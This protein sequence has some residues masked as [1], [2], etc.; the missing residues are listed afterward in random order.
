MAS[1][2]ERWGS[3]WEIGRIAMKLR[4]LPEKIKQKNDYINNL[5]NVKPQN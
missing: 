5:P 3:R 4:I 1:S 2:D